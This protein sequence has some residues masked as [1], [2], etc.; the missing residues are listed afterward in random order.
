VTE[1]AQQRG[2]VRASKK[3]IGSIETKRDAQLAGEQA[4]AERR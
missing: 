1:G 3:V 4:L 2:W